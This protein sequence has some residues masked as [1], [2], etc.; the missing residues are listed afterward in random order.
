M[1]LPLGFSTSLAL[2]PLFCHL[3]GDT[4]VLL[5]LLSWTIHNNPGPEVAE[6]QSLVCLL[7][8]SE[9]ARYQLIHTSFENFYSLKNPN[10]TF[11]EEQLA[12]LS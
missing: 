10:K 7:Q 1:M 8:F 4:L 6:N 3:F 12:F 2:G 11:W 5:K 9:S